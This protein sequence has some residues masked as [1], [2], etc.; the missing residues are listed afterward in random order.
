MK[1]NQMNIKGQ[2]AFLSK[3]KDQLYSSKVRNKPFLTF[4]LTP[5]EVRIL[6]QIIP[7]DMFVSYYGGYAQAQRQVAFVSPFEMTPAFDVDI[8]SASYDSRYKVLTHRDL[9]GALMHLGIER[10]RIGDLIVDQDR[11][12]IICKKNLSEFIQS[13]LF[14]IGRCHVSFSLDNDAQIHYLGYEI[15]N[16]GVASLRVDAIVSALKHCS[17]SQSAT[18]INQGL[19][20]VND[21]VLEQNCQLCNNDF[22]S[23]RGV[24][25]FQ[26]IEVSHTTKKDRLV[27]QVKKFI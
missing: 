2:E 3:I 8:L 17:R 20:K 6:D 13:N 22:V 14:Q 21:V 1:N 27:L 9:L 25:R 5:V 4:F 18:M 23:I 19:I 12:Y 7:K 10:N 15:I 16:V 24:G 11:I 26:F